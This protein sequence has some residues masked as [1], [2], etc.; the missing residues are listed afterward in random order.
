MRQAR[1]QYTP[2]QL[3]DTGETTTTQLFGPAQQI[4]DQSR[5]LLAPDF[6]QSQA[7]LGLHLW[8]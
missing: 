7:G 2:T 1:W 4:Q 6:P 3:G 5:Q 8:Q